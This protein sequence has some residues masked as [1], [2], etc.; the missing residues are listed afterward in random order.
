[1]KRLK[2]F[3]YIMASLFGLL[4]LGFLAA[5]ALGFMTLSNTQGTIAEQEYRLNAISERVSILSALDKKYEALKED[6][7]LIN[8]ALPNEKESSKLI[9]DL[10]TLANTSGLKLTLVQSATTGKKATSEDPSLLQTIKGT[11]GYEIP[12]EIKVEGG[13]SSFTG[14]VKKLENYQ[15]L[16][17]VTSIEI[18][19]PTGVGAGGDNIEAKLKIT[20]YLKK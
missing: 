1:M 5:G 17:N 7:N 3:Y 16:V 13:F 19:K 9:A 11:Y 8:I 12:L 18:T 15:R 6:I 4:A 2:T 10:D 14:F 20:A